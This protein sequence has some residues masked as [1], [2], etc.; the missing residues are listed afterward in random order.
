MKKLL[1]LMLIS[2]NLYGQSTEQLNT[3]DT[4]YPIKVYA[5]EQELICF[6]KKQANM[7]YRDWQLL[8]NC[9]R[10]ISGKDSL[11][12]SLKTENTVLQDLDLNNRSE[13]ELKDKK[14]SL[15]EAII[16]E[17]R[18]QLTLSKRENIINQLSSKNKIWNIAAI[19]LLSGLVVGYAIAK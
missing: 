5:G 15:Y 19:S 3:T 17:N 6:K 7:I 4:L 2:F 13:I 10:A 14:L 16:K 1:L 9:N 18:T 8:L 11:I 12:N